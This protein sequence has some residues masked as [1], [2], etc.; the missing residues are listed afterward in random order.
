MDEKENEKRLKGLWD[1]NNISDISV[2][3]VLEGEGEGGIEKAFDEIMAEN[4]PHQAREI[5]PQ[6]KHVERTSGWVNLN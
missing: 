3:G 6:L 1:C 2:T 5:N 4:S